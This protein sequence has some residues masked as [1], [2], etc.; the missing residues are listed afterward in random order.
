VSTQREQVLA[1]WF[2]QRRRA[3][4]ATASSNDVAGAA[5]VYD[6]SP[7]SDAEEW[8]NCAKDSAGEVI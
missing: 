8:C 2:A 6:R 5:H 1:T 7:T 3:G 4:S